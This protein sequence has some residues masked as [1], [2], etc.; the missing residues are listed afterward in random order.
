MGSTWD[1]KVCLDRHVAMNL[2]IVVRCLSFAWKGMGSRPVLASVRLA[3]LH[4]LIPLEWQWLSLPMEVL[5][6]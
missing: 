6:L 5:D 2:V 3:S 1:V 4:P